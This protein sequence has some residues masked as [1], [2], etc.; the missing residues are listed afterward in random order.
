MAVHLIKDVRVIEQLGI[1]AREL[2]GLQEAGKHLREE[3]GLPATAVTLI[4]IVDLPV[5]GHR[6]PCS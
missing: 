1:T 3:E 2:D 6:C 4:V 5:H